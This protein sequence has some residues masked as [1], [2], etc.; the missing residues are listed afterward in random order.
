MPIDRRA[1]LAGA[2][3][4][5]AIPGATL[6]TIAG[7]APQRL[8]AAT[9][10]KNNIIA[11]RFEAADMALPAIKL[12]DG[13][14]VV[15]LD[16]LTGKTRIV[17]LWAEW[18]TPCLVE[19]RDFAALRRRYAGADFDIVSVL[20]GSIQGLDFTRALARLQQS[21]V[22]GLP[23]LVEPHGGKRVMEKLSVNADG[24]GASLPCTLL[25]DRRGRIRARARGAP[26]D[27][28]PTRAPPAPG[29]KPVIR[30][31]TE[32]DKR[33]LLTNGTHTLWGG[34]AGDAF[35]GALQKGLLDQV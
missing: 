16:S 15:R 9:A 17:T 19:A 31:L 4:T 7:P 33:A 20:T 26:M 18:C 13:K 22:D 24:R 23:L 27:V 1:F 8:F 21:G 2:G 5:M 35:A 6:A 10:M 34:A 12:S 28:D 32:A 30:I 14:D 11:N 29:G 25:V 3:A